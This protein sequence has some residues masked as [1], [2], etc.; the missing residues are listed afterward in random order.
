MREQFAEKDR[1]TRQLNRPKAY[2]GI[3]PYLFV[4]YSHKDG[5]L[6]YPII[7]GMQQHGVRVW[8]DDGIRAGSEF[9]QYIED[10]LV[11][12]ACILQF[13]TRNTV[14]SFFC[15]NEIGLA[16]D[17]HQNQTFIVYLEE[18]ELKYGL[19]LQ[20][21]NIQAL[22]WEK[23]HETQEFLNALLELLRTN[24]AEVFE[25]LED[26]SVVNLNRECSVQP[27][28]LRVTDVQNFPLNL[29]KNIQTVEFYGLFSE[30]EKETCKE[31]TGIRKV[32]LP[33]TVRLIDKWAFFGCTDLEAIRFPDELQHIGDWA[34]E[35]CKKLQG[36]LSLTA[37]ESIGFRSFK[38]CKELRNL[39]LPQIRS[40]GGWAFSECEKLENASCGTTLTE[41]GESAFYHCR[42]LQTVEWQGAAYQ[43]EEKTFCGCISLRSVTLPATVKRIGIGAFEGCSSLVQIE[44]PKNLK[45]IEKSAFAGCS[46]L[47]EICI[48]EGVQEIGSWSFSD[49]SRLKEVELPDSLEILRD[50]AFANCES[51]TILQIPAECRLEG[52]PIP[53][54]C[55]ILRRKKSGKYGFLGLFGKRMG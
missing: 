20:L 28:V 36:S 14:E 10:T 51:L 48:P 34:F 35:N 19:R 21:R 6:V 2:E 7:Q 46:K 32:V 1:N 45:R 50:G 54:S 33:D 49:C 4:S 3:K 24:A 5:A 42:M 41:L 30:V 22:R 40:I 13:V 8:Y 27:N 26:E 55:R 11:Q 29:D 18:T 31:C 17:T 52:R 12:A 38:G 39:V 9:P 43:V 44:L 15:R 47:E 25:T 23:Y 53:A 37:L 16:L